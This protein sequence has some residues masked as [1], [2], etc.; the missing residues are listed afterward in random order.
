M[1]NSVLM[2]RPAARAQ[3]GFEIVRQR[4]FIRLFG[5]AAAAWSLA[6]HAD[7]PPKRA[8]EATAT[9]FLHIETA[10]VKPVDQLFQSSRLGDGLVDLMKDFSLSGSEGIGNAWKIPPYI[11]VSGDSFD[12]RFGGW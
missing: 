6:A 3:D 9:T 11:A 7:A 12:Q 2:T 1:L 5:C 8:A 10:H 4:R